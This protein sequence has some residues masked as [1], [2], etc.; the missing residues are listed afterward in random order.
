M[1]F[2]RM[3]AARRAALLRHKQGMAGLAHQGRMT[4]L[5]EKQLK[6]QKKALPWQIGLGLA[7]TAYGF[8]EGRRR[9]GLLDAERV[10]RN[11]R[12][13]RMDR[14]AQGDFSDYPGQGIDEMQESPI[15]SS[16]ATRSPGGHRGDIYA[17]GRRNL[18]GGR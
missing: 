13:A 2:E 15:K 4:G 1:D 8:A 3:E 17:P 18:Y 12:T 9:A 14:F 16:L 11:A 6:D 10:K 5:S 7:G